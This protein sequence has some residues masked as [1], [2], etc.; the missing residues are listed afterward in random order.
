MTGPGGVVL[1]LGGGAGPTQARVLLPDSVA[2]ADGRALA[3]ACR[4]ASK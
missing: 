3:L 1:R 4:A 2:P